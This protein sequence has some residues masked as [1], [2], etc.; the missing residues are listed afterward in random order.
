MDKDIKN[1][2]QD[3][4]RKIHKFLNQLPGRSRLVL[5]SA[6]F[7]ILIVL[8]F[9]MLSKGADDD[10]LVDTSN[11]DIKVSFEGYDGYGKAKAEI[12]G[13]PA[14]KKL[15]DKDK[16]DTLEREL[17]DPE[18]SFSKQEGLKNGDEIIV[19]VKYET[20]S[21]KAKFSC[22][23][24]EKKVS[25]EGLPKLINSVADIDEMDLA[26][27]DNKS[28]EKI[29]DMYTYDNYSNLKINRIRVYEK[30]NRNED[31]QAGLGAANNFKCLFLY[32]VEYDEGKY[33]KKH[34]STLQSVEFYNFD[35]KGGNLEYLSAMRNSAAYSND[36]SSINDRLAAEGFEEYEKLRDLA[37]GNQATIPT[38]SANPDNSAN[39]SNQTS[40]E[41]PGQ[42]GEAPVSRAQQDKADSLVGQTLEVRHGGNLRSQA[43]MDSSVIIMLPKGTKVNIVKTKAEPYRIWCYVKATKKDG[44][45]YEGWMSD[46]VIK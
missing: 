18:I 1:K 29:A 21:V 38:N 19:T 7:V 46:K 27:M 30:K 33:T 36:L 3:L 20:K 28:L 5:F 44:T 45:Q 32:R 42:S 12:I 31:M 13:K 4:K 17:A 43:G 2:S 34:K 37:T 40:P 41:D 8:A 23:S 9:L 24:I 35:A 14:I 10:N 39:P 26:A 25:V 22:Q 16:Y 11:L 15:A 6:I